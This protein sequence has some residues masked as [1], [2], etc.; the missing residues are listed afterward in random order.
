[1][2]FLKHLPAAVLAVGC[3]TSPPAKQGNAAPAGATEAACNSRPR[4]CSAFRGSGGFVEAYVRFIYASP[5][6]LAAAFPLSVPTDHA[7]PKGVPGVTENGWERANS[8]LETL[9]G[10]KCF[11]V[12]EQELDA[13]ADALGISRP[14]RR[15]PPRDPKR[16]AAVL[17]PFTGQ[18]FSDAELK[19]LK[20]SPE[21]HLIPVRHTP[22][23]CA[24]IYEIP[25]NALDRLA[26]EPDQHKLGDRWLA[27]I[28]AGGPNLAAFELEPNQADPRDDPRQWSTLA[29]DLIQLA[30]MRNCGRPNLYVEI[31]YDC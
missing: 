16:A 11:S 22:D 19:N 13:L 24:T 15:G 3:A 26:A 12:S 4:E 8:L 9:A 21:S 30:R 10:L 7:R 14:A 31:A 27:S 6:E 18:P 2:R 23:A 1:M 20:P 25:R 5:S 29:G 17:N 28:R